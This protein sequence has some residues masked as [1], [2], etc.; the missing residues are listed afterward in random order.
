MGR[1]SKKS[2][3]LLLTM[4]AIFTIFAHGS[5]TFAGQNIKVTLNKSSYEYTGKAVKPKVKVVYK[6][7]KLSAKKYTVKYSSGRKNVGK[8]AVTI[9]LK[10][11]YSGSKKVFFTI[12]PTKTEISELSPEGDG[13]CVKWKKVSKQITG[14]QVVY[15][16]SKSFED[17][18]KCNVKKKTS[19]IFNK[20]DGSTVYY[21]RV[22]SYSKVKGKT[23]YSKWSKKKSIKTNVQYHFRNDYLLTEH[24]NKHGIEMGFE[25]KEEYEAAAARVV[26]NPNSLHK[27]ESEDGDDCYY[28][29]ETNEFVIVS[30]DGYIRTYFKPDSGKDY[31][32]RQ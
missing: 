18:S 12:N 5:F 22:R 29:E 8:Y 11:P 25:T 17:A 24:F 9:K 31:F 10:K 30:T 3:L 6:G 27:I 4:L 2:I 26:V 20:L 21:V 19:K 1:F 28:L 16:T 14:Y 15:S 23:Y 32:D 7:K 13:F